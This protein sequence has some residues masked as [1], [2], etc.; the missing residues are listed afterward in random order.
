M[1]YILKSTQDL[2][3]AAYGSQTNQTP[4]A[5]HGLPQ[6]QSRAALNVAEFC[7]LVG[8]GRTL[9]Y[10]LVNEGRIR[11]VCIGG[12]RLIPISEVNRLLE[13]GGHENA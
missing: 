2:T 12:R 1:Q 13:N 4:D 5:I 7:Q 3:E 10:K 6:V 8:I 11:T 9:F